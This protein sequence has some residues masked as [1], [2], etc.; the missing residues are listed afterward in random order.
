MSQ[1]AAVNASPFPSAATCLRYKELNVAVSYN[2]TESERH[3]Y[4]SFLFSVGQCEIC[5]FQFV[6]DFVLYSFVFVS[7][8]SAK[9]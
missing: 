8:L 5:A 3:T 4:P 6:S 2:C 9:L 7:I 1:Y